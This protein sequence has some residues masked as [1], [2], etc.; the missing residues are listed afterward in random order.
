MVTYAKRE[1]V[2]IE[3]LESKIDIYQMLLGLDLISSVNA[4]ITC[5]TSFLQN[6]LLLYQRENII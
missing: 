4:L 3:I 5:F 6:K 2:K 1:L